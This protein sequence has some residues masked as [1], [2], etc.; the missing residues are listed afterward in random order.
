MFAPTTTITPGPDLPPITC[1]EDWAR[2][3]QTHTHEA[4]TT[5]ANLLGNHS[6]PPVIDS[7]SAVFI[8]PDNIQHYVHGNCQGTTEVQ[9]CLSGLFRLLRLTPPPVSLLQQ[10]ELDQM[11]LLGEAPQRWK[12]EHR[13][14]PRDS[15][16]DPLGIPTCC[17]PWHNGSDHFVTFYMC[18]EYWTIIYPLCPAR[19]SYPAFETQLQNALHESFT[20]RGLLSP[21][22]P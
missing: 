8:T 12:R 16:R 20:A 18:K 21:T 2:L 14:L 9:D 19:A 15:Y 11:L 1:I 4:F 6:C 5:F 10:Q 22:L 3:L 17:G 13:F 7:S